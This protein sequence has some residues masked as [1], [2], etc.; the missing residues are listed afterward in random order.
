MVAAA[1][2]GRRFQ[3]GPARLAWG[4]LS[5]QDQFGQSAV[6]QAI[7]WLTVYAP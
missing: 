7:S 1:E 2:P 6:G 3:I 4:K 5:P